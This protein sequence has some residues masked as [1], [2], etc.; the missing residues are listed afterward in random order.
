MSGF[1]SRYRYDIAVF[2]TSLAL[3]FF[4][5]VIY[6]TE[7]ARV[8]AWAAIFFIQVCW[9]GYVAYRWTWDEQPTVAE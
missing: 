3:V 1:L 2:L 4:A 5:Y 7:L 6:P 9:V 8:G